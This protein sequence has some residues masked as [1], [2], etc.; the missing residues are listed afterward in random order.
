MYLSAIRS[1]HVASGRH[2]D[3]ARQLTPRLQQVIKG[4]QKEQA[5]TRPPRVR[6]PITLDIMQGIQSVLAQQPQ[7]YYNIMIWAAC[8]MAFFGFLR[9]SEFTVPS[10]SQFDPNLHLTLSDITLDSRHSPQ[11]IQVN[12]KQ[13]K[14]DPFRQGITLSLGR[15]DHKI[16]PVKAIVPFL[17]ASGKGPGPLFQLQNQ[18]MLTRGMFSATLD[19]ILTQLHLDKDQFNTHSFRIG[20]ATSAKRA[21]MADV[22]IKMLGRWRSEAYQR[23][24]RM[25]PTDLARL[26]K[27]LVSDHHNPV[28]HISTANRPQ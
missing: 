5:I 8:A 21:G 14:T 13:S 10:Q 15:T 12:I 6:L 28:S 24:V 7:K 19:K 1:F 18:Q 27:K 25:S 22:D 23:Y 20:A 17:A 9:S 2:D 4:I 3:F 16:C 26:S 11:I